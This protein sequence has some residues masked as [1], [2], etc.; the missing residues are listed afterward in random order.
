VS[1]FGD[2]ERLASDLYPYRWPITISLAVLAVLVAAFA[3]RRGWHRAVVRHKLASAVVAAVVIAAAVPAVDYFLSPLWERTHL[4]EPSPLV[5]AAGPDP[6]SAPG[7]I[8]STPPVDDEPT[9]PAF[10]AR[11]THQGAFSGADDFHFGRGNALLIETAPG[12]YTLRFEEFSVRNG[13]DLFVYLTSD[14]DSVDGAVN[15]G[16]LKATDGAFNY[17]VPAGSDVSRFTHAIVWCRQFA[18]LF[19]SAPLDEVSG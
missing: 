10:E 7:G 8:A 3:Y 17:E 5:E 14:R 11:V 12:R 6:T 9:V 2:L 13:P 4:E 19:A 15:L 16:D 1:F 18:V